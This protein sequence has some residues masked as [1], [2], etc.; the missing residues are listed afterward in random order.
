MDVVIM[1]IK[2]YVLAGAEHYRCFDPYGP[3]VDRFSPNT[4]IGRVSN[5]MRNVVNQDPETRQFGLP[6][7]GAIAGRYPVFANLGE[8]TILF[9]SAPGT[10]AGRYAR[11]VVLASV[12]INA[13]W[14]GQ[15]A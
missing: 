3:R 7:T 8:Q 10:S 15:Y 13:H 11:E 5:R 4:G 14:R 9:Q 12:W 6:V 1:T 2:L